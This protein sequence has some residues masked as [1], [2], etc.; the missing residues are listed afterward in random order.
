MNFLY[1]L[2]NKLGHRFYPED[3]IPIHYKGKRF[4]SPFQT[5]DDKEFRKVVTSKIFTGL[6]MIVLC[7]A[8]AG[9]IPNLFRLTFS[10]P[11]S[12]TVY[13]YWG[14]AG[15]ILGWVPFVHLLCWMTYGYSPERVEYLVERDEQAE[16]MRQQEE[17]TMAQLAELR[18]NFA[19]AIASG[20]GIVMN[21]DLIPMGEE[22]EDGEFSAPSYTGIPKN[23]LH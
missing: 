2:F 12:W 10:I 21:Q 19:E 23:K 11:F 9:L 16:A 7:V 18:R 20:G 4:Y 14:I 5:E 6:I 17:A 8:V 3:M 15:S 1:K 13:M 22:A